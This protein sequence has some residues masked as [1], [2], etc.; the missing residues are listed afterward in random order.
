MYRTQNQI[1]RTQNQ[2]YTFTT[3][4]L[5]SFIDESKISR[6]QNWFYR[7]NFETSANETSRNETYMNTPLI[8]NDF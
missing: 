7:S 3:D 1:Y 4:P 6:F 8:Y 2:I 5:L